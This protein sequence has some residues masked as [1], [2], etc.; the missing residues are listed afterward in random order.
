MHVD[1]NMTT[2]GVEEI[3]NKDEILYR[4]IK[5]THHISKACYLLPMFPKWHTHRGIS[6]LKGR[7]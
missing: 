1:T 6:G 2:K 7:I 5:D 3:E 4:Y